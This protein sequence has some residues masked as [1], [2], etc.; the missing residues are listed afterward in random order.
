MNL[1]ILS[2]FLYINVSN[3]YK[4]CV[5][6]ASSA[7]GREVIYQSLNDKKFNVLGFTNN[8]D[9][10]CE[11]YRG[12]GLNDKS[13]KD[14]ITSSNLKLLPY[15]KISNDI[16][17]DALVI[18][19][20]GTA[21]EKNDYSAEVTKKLIDNLPNS[22]KTISLVSAYGVGDSINKA[23]FG[24]VSMKNWYLKNVYSSKEEQENIIKNIKKG[25]KKNIYRPKVLSYGKTIFDSTPREKLA[26]QILDEL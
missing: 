6:G 17:Y 13:S 16:N 5:A 7:L 25:I 23:N 14:L 9:K 26:K 20:G 11:P 24:I 4:I 19:I 21:F 8:F 2:I 22:C 12:T 15:S 3:S 18:S 10:V 1:F